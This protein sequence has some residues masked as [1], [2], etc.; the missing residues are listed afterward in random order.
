MQ[1][2]EKQPN[3]HQINTLK[4]IQLPDNKTGVKASELYRALGLQTVN[5]QRWIKK[6]IISDRFSVENIDY[7]VLTNPK[8]ILRNNN[9]LLTIPNDETVVKNNNKRLRNRSRNIDF[10][11][12]LDFAKLLTMQTRTFAGHEVRLYFLECEKAL[13]YNA[14]IVSEE[15]QRE[16]EA[17]REIFEIEEIRKQ[18]NA[19]TRRAKKIIKQS[20]RTI[21]NVPFVQLT[22]SY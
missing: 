18:L 9:P 21:N 13:Q 7:Y 22:F 1:H 20:Q 4:I 5:Y 17:Y 19:R 12:T 2:L 6:N 16:L 15:M 11:L 3:Q 8:D 10:L 14:K